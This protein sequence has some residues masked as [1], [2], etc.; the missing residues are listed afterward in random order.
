MGNHSS[1]RESDDGD[2]FGL[3]DDADSGQTP[4]E[5]TGELS[6]DA[7]REVLAGRGEPTVS[8]DDGPAMPVPRPRR[9]RRRGRRRVL[10]TVIVVVVIAL[11]VGGLG[12][13]YLLWRDSTA[14]PTDWAGTGERTVVVRVHSG[15]GLY[16]VGQ[17]LVDAG[18]VATVN[19]F[20]KIASDDGRLRALQPGYYLVHEHSSAQSVVEDLA[21]PNNRLGQLRIIPGQTLADITT[22]STDGEEG[23]R[24]G[25]LST[26]AEA[27]VP[28]N[29]A[30]ECF[31]LDELWDAAVTATAADLGVVGWAVDDVDAA[32]EERRRL[33]GLILP[34]DYD[35]APGSTALEALRAVV[36]AS[37]A[38]W[39][40]TEIVPAAATHDLTPYQLA[41]VASLAEAEANNASDMRKVARVIYNRLDDDMRL[42]FDSTVNYGLDR[43][44]IATRQSERMDQ[45]NLYSTYAH[46]GLTPTPIGAP[47][48]DALDAAADPAIG[49]WLFFVTIDL[50]GHTCFSV[51]DQEHE[52]CVDQAR[53]NGVFG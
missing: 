31:T 13:G 34:G 44:S 10:S 43:A 33:E 51:T 4:Q 49:E 40:T 29:G 1:G 22:V 41:T 30:S 18:V 28:T 9:A 38:R 5:A 27:C 52:E 24:R 42:Q 47:G 48:P 35:I 53:A 45:S 37:A 8:D 12:Y 2:H 39:N 23:T 3:F 25:I 6:L 15:E 21:D 7:L 36:S 14:A 50:D 20:V 19:T 32:P 26:I 11:I 17:T 16:D 46:Y